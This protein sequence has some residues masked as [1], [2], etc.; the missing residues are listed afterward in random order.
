MFSLTKAGLALAFI[1]GTNGCTQST[2]EVSGAAE[3]ASCPGSTN[4][5]TCAADGSTNYHSWTG[6]YNETDGK[7]YGTMTTNLCSNDDWGY[8]PLCDP[9]GFLPYAYHSAYCVTQDFPAPAYSEGPNGAPLRGRVGLSMNGVNI[10]GP[11]EAGFGFGSNPSPC[12][13][14]SGTCYAGVDVPTCEASLEITCDAEGNASKIVHSLMLDTCGG[15]ATPYHYHNDLACDYDHTVADHSPLI[16]IAL[17]GY[18][19]YGLYESYDADTSTQVKPDDLDTCNGHAKAVPANTTY[20]VDGA[21]VYHYHT[22]SWAPYTIGCFGV[23]EGVDQDSCKELYPYSDSGST[24]GCGD[25]IYGITTPET[26]GGYCYGGLG[27][28]PTPHR[29]VTYPRT[30]LPPSIQVVTSPSATPCSSPLQTRTVLASIAPR[31]ATAA[32]RTWPSTAPTAARA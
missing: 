5:D 19:I 16:G 22:T 14:G 29:P 7:F 30:T 4:G 25:G 12:S 32:T 1:S 15:H 26:P 8:C 2:Y 13:D 31:T 21:S 11:E 23:P 10:Y 18:G 6:T 27:I 24:G 20:G 3:S 9:P 28:M 17:D